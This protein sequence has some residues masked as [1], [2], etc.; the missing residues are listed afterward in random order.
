MYTIFHLFQSQNH[1]FHQNVNIE[2]SYF[3]DFPFH[4]KKCK[5]SGVLAVNK[6]TLHFGAKNF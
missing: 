6:K 4:E 5:N 3:T 2:N 1:T